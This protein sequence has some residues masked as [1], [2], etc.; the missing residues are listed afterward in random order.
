MWTEVVGGIELAVGVIKGYV[1]EC[2]WH[3][4]QLTCVRENYPTVAEKLKTYEVVIEG[5][6]IKV[7]T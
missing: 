7:L 5:G 2:D 1:V 4:W 6:L 3:G